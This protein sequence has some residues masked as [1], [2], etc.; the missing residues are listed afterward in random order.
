[1]PSPRDFEAVRSAEAFRVE[2]GVSRE[3]AERLDLYVDHLLK[4]QKRLNLIGR[5]TIPEIWT[6]HILDSAQLM[7]HLPPDCRTLVDLGSGAGLPGLVLAILGV[8]DVHL[9]ESDTRK[10][11][12][13]REAARLTGT[14]VTVH[15]KRVDQCSGIT[16]DV[17]TARALAPF[18]VLLD[19]ARP[20]AHKG[21]VMVFPKGQD[22]QKELEMADLD[23]GVYVQT[24]SSQTSAQGVV[25]RVTLDGH[26]D[27]HR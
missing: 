10:A 24:L 20:F 12:F 23:A 18:H 19:M 1:M 4:W 5:S 13:L 11:V 7:N 26:F 22:S 21:T 25:L 17:I 14:P 15:S 8:P 2:T 6:R 16:G 3:T 9:I 27:S